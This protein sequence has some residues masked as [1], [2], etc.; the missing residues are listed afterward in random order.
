M[1]SNT[2]RCY[3]TY[4]GLYQ[5]HTDVFEGPL[6]LLLLLIEK[7]KLLINDIALAEVADDFLKYIERHPE[8]PVAETAQF[9]L[10]GSDLLLIKSRSLLPSLRLSEEEQAS[11]ENLEFRLK[12]LERYKKLG[13]QLQST[14]ALTPL[15][16]R[17]RRGVLQ[18]VFSPDPG[19]HVAGLLDAVRS[20][21]RQLPKEK[22][23]LPQAMVQKVVSLE[24]MMERLSERIS[25]SME[26]SFRDTSRT[27]GS[28]V[29]TIVTFLALLELVRQGVVRVEQE[30]QFGDI[31]M[32]SDAVGIPRYG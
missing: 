22:V 23:A 21:L 13:V 24:E 10:T 9:V 32:R 17:Q 6:E 16:S 8:F 26:V 1:H 30:A 31:R 15:Y 19:M 20:V 14:Y 18:V 2:A 7:R 25:A 12:A 28:K 11:V 3:N 29:N 5:L 27:A 4:M